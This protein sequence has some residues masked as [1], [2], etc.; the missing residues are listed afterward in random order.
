[1]TE[2]EFGR[3]VIQNL[4]Q[5][6]KEKR[7]KW[8]NSDGSALS[9]PYQSPADKHF[10]IDFV[11]KAPPIHI[12]EQEIDAEITYRFVFHRFDERWGDTIHEETQRTFKPEE[13]DKELIEILQNCIKEGI[14]ITLAERAEEEKKRKQKREKEEQKRLEKLLQKSKG[15]EIKEKK[16]KPTLDRKFFEFMHR[17]GYVI[18]G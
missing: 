7:I 3:Q 9:Y 13:Q 18:F 10:H 15:V 17:V 12:V 14:Q 4:I 6:S 1:M 11:K 8:Y 16:V 5:A 2:Q